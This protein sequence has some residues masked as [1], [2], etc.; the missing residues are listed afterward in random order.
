MA[1]ARHNL[2]GLCLAFVFAWSALPTVGW[3]GPSLTAAA[4]AAQDMGD[5]MPQ[6]RSG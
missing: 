4:V 6:T 5:T 1:E 3:A 2:P